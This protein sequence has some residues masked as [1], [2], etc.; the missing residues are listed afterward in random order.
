M[1]RAEQQVVEVPGRQGAS[2]SHTH[3]HALNLSFSPTESVQNVQDPSTRPSRG[4]QDRIVEG[5]VMREEEARSR[6][7]SRDGQV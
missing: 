6:S 7:N 2:Y 1:K 3:I 4:T 5:S